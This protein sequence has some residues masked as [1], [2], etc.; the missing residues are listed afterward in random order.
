MR[1][2]AASRL[3]KMIIVVVFGAAFYSILYH[4]FLPVFINEFNTVDG[5]VY[6]ARFVDVLFALVIFMAAAFYLV[7]TYVEKRRILHF[8]AISLA[9][10]AVLSLL[11]HQLHLVIL[12]L[13]NLPTG[14]NE[15]SDKMIT[16]YRRKS[17]DFPIL[18]VNLVIYTLGILYGMSRDWIRKSRIES[19]LV[20][21]KMKAE[22]DL[23]RSQINPHFFFNALN[24]IYAITQRNGEE[25]TGEAIMKLS[26]LMRHMIYDSSAAAIGLDRELEHV[27]NFIEVARLKLAGDENV[28]INLTEKG[29]IRS[30]KI[31]PLILIPFVEN[32]FKHGVGSRGEGFINLAVEVEDGE[33]VFQVKNPVLDKGKSV[34]KHS[35]IGLDNVG[36]RLSLLYP[37]RHTL[38]IA[39]EDGLFD[40]ELSIRLKE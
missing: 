37:G 18:P 2:T 40:V 29:D 30:V 39:E 8:A 33:L 26:G 11:H 13:F 10:L 22:I 21:E 16:Y 14:P 7:P 19:R 5:S 3:E 4:P 15:I 9:G 35:G 24:N 1:P 34:Q 20:K 28:D 12:R 25:E 17:Y 32:A 27:K 23:L 38:V 6:A 36:K 31:A